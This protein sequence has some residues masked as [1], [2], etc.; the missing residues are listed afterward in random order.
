MYYSDQLITFEGLL[1]DAEDDAELLTAFWESNLDGELVDVD[2]E[3]D[4][5]GAVVGYGYLSEG[6]HAIELHVEDTTGKTARET[7][8]IEV[9]PPNST[10][11]T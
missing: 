4:S 2:T 10:F 6:E 7:T 11:V 8:I 9:G 1:S 5:N 3:V